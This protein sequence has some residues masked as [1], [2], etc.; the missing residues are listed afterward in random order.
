MDRGDYGYR[1]RSGIMSRQKLISITVPDLLIAYDREAAGIPIG[2]PAEVNLRNN[3]TQYIF[4]WY[5]I[6]ESLRL[7]SGDIACKSV[8]LLTSYHRYS[9]SAATA[10][11]FWM[12][13]RKPPSD[14][15]R[16]V[17]QNKAW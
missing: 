8:P 15:A 1:S 4:T 10:I 14:I 17:R 12:L 5:V 13:V 6:L 9:L 7:W 16:R 2:R 11:M 3:H